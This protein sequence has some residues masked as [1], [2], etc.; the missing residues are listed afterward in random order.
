VRRSQTDLPS[1]VDVCDAGR[2]TLEAI[3]TMDGDSDPK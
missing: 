1:D 2:L 3:I